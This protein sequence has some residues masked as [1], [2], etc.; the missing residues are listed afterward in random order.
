MQKPDPTENFDLWVRATYEEVRKE[1]AG[2]TPEQQDK[3][4]LLKSINHAIRMY[5]LD[6]PAF[7]IKM[8]NAKMHRHLGKLRERAR[9]KRQDAAGVSGSAGLG[10]GTG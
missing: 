8:A 9:K 2:M 4:F 6:A 7:L 10:F 3:H 1:I 5:E